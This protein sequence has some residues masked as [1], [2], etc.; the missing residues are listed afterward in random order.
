MGTT[1]LLKQ[2]WAAFYSTLESAEPDAPT[3]CGDWTTRVLAGHVVAT[4]K[5]RG[6]PVF[7]AFITG[8]IGI[9][10][11]GPLRP[12]AQRQFGK[13]M[14]REIAR[15]YPALLDEL[16][17]GPP[18]TY[19]FPGFAWVRLWEIWVH[20]EDVRRPT[21]AG[22]RLTTPELER[23]FWKMV[24]LIG[25][26]QGRRFGPVGVL[27]VNLDGGKIRLRKGPTETRI[28]GQ[29][30]EILLF[31]SGRRDTARVDLEGTEIDVAAVL[32]A[33]LGV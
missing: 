20:H 31:L 6:I 12:I 30:S 8:L 28:V 29:P 18:L 15:G 19:R 14:D 10:T 7:L 33:P 21:G 16:R 5:G 2:E 22:P 9:T 11:F 13:L 3:S 27:A 1:R 17:R 26:P 4:Q 23:I 32:A 25:M 24:A